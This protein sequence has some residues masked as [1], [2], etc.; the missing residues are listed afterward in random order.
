VVET[1]GPVIAKLLR[2]LLEMKVIGEA[3]VLLAG[4]DSKA[5]LTVKD[6]HA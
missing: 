5:N 1:G 4:M 2:L 6:L 3:G